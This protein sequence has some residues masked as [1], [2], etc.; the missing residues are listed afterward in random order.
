[1][2]QQQNT[3]KRTRDDPNNTTEA[4]RVCSM[5]S[6]LTLDPRYDLT[7]TVG[8]PEQPNGQRSFRVNSGIFRLASPVWS[9]MLD[10]CYI[11]SDM[12]EILFPE[13]DSYAFQTVL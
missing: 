7:L 9:A 2:N 12:S 4:K 6:V 1:M 8:K 13:D 5:P 10:G 3:L 11:E